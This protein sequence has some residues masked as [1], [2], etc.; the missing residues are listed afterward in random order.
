LANSGGY[1][2]A[3]SLS[4]LFVVT[5]AASDDLSGRWKISYVVQS[6]SPDDGLAE[7]SVASLSEKDVTL[8]GRAT[9]ADAV[10]AT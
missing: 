10:M 7:G 1:L 8:Q 4:F 2:L 6:G 5:A 3:A 9:W